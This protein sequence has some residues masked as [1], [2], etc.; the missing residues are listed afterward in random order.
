MPRRQSKKFKYSHVWG[1]GNCDIGPGYDL[2]KRDHRDT[3]FHLGQSYSKMCVTTLVC[4]V[5][6][7]YEFNVG[8]GDY[9]TVIRCPKCHWELAIHDG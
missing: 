4:A 2:A 3:R 9:L 5:C 7:G 1:D 8:Q 6:G